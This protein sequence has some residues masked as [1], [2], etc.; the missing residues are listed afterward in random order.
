M[1]TIDK[2][3]L[4]ERSRERS[5]SVFVPCELG[6]I[7]S[8]VAG[9]HAALTILSQ[10]GVENSMAIVDAAMDIKEY[11]RDKTHELEQFGINQDRQIADE[12]AATERRKLAIKRVSEDL[13]FAVLQRDAAVKALLMDVKQYAAEVEIEQLDVERQ[14]VGVAIAKEGLRLKQ[15]NAGIFLEYINKKMVEVDIAKHRVEAAKAN[16]RAVI[17]GIEAGEAEIKL[18]NA[19]IEVYMQ[20]ADKA[21][22]QADVATIYAQIMSKELSQVKLD[23][24]RAE[25]EAGFSYIATKLS[26]MAAIY[27][28]KNIVEQIKGDLERALLNELAYYADAERYAEYQKLDEQMGHKRVLDYTEAVTMDSIGAEAVVKGRVWAAKDDLALTRLQNS[29]RADD[30][31]TWATKLI[32]AAHEYVYGHSFQWFTDITR[33]TEYISGG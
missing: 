17:A 33:N 16:V 5:Q 23:V 15:A 4:R 24:N 21:G 22:L 26:D 31:H 3:Q 6:G 32:A 11:Q 12:K 13:Q 25:I 20:E 18:L 7:L 30:M 10:S 9:R 28:V 27:G 2:V 8:P 14:R 29:M 19:Q 1:D